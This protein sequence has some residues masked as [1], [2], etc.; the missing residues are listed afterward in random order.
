LTRVDL[1]GKLDEQEFNKNIEERSSEGLDEDF[2]EL[3]LI[4]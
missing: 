1:D 2:I 3:I 4:C